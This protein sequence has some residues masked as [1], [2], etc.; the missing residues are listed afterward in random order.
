MQLRNPWARPAWFRQSYGFLQTPVLKSHCTSVSGLLIK[1]SHPTSFRLKCYLENTCFLNPN[2]TDSCPYF[3][4][5]ILA[6]LSPYPLLISLVRAYLSSVSQAGG[7]VR[8]DLSPLVTNKEEK[9]FAP[10]QDASSLLWSPWD[11]N[12]P[13]FSIPTPIR[14]SQTIECKTVQHLGEESVFSGTLTFLA[15]NGFSTYNHLPR[16]SH[17]SRQAWGSSLPGFHVYSLLWLPLCS[18]SVSSSGTIQSYH[19]YPQ[20]PQGVAPHLTCRFRDP[21]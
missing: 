18:P 9:A 17:S 14:C 13:W 8:G 15:Q 16:A 12:S 11:A 21:T 5:V 4:K 20:G 2:H 7:Q 19:H 10:H 1:S 3:W 6:L